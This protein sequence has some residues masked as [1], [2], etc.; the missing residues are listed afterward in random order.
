MDI[1]I[2][3]RKEVDSTNDWARQMA[4]EG[5][6]SGTL[7][8]AD[9]QTNGR[10][11]RGHD[12]ESPMGDNIYMS[13]ILRPEIPGF[14][15][16]QLT[17]VMGLSVSQGISAV[18]GLP[19]MMKWPND[20]ILSGKK[21]CG[22]LTEMSASRTK[23]NYVIIGIGINVNNCVFSAELADTATSLKLA[24]GHAVDKCEIMNAV[25]DAFEKNY[26]I[27]LKTED[28]SGIQEEYNKVLVNRDREVRVLDPVNPYEGIARG[29]N[30]IG[31]LLV[32]KP[33]KT[34]EK[35][36]AGEVSIRGVS[37]YI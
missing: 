4:E 26:N 7:A 15:A 19:V 32:E 20:L 10:G 36:Y 16:S 11:R 6:C 5:A 8:L 9:T 33:D 17:L 30:K 25:F 13:L 1:K 18:L 29:I 31:E 35:V 2:C 37:S 12:W 24:S 28:L 27:F 14:K 34:V 21:I 23:I 3:Y 22:I